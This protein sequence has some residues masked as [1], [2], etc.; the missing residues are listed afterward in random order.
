MQQLAGNFGLGHTRYPTQGSSGS[1]L[2][3]PFYVNSPY[4][5][6]LAHNGNL[7]NSA[8]LS[9]ELYQTDLRHLNT[10][11]D[12]EVLLN[13][14]AHELQRQGKLSPSADDV[15]NAVTTLHTRCEG[16][17]AAIAMIANVGLNGAGVFY[18]ALLPHMGDESEM[19]AIS[20][21]AFAA[22]YLGGG[23][24]LVVHLGMWLTLDGGWVIPFIMASSGL[25]W[26]GFAQMTFKMVPEPHIENEMESMG[27]IASS[28]MAL[29]EV[30]STMKDIKKFQNSIHLHVSILLFH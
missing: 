5:I 23:I 8:A 17:Y 22:G 13:V 9:E 29:N 15:F 30:I 12:S 7:T 18:N 11:S 14:F 19:D 27:L 26:L 21:K 4:G 10:D 20:N 6:A 28:K 1:A 3:Q 16:G 25:W 2:A 24:L